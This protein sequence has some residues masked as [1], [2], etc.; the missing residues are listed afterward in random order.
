MYAFLVPIAFGWA[1]FSTVCWAIT[2][3][4]GIICGL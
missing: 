3:R 4:A 2:V 1:L